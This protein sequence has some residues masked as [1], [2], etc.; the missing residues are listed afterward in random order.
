MVP[1]LLNACTDAEHLA[2]KVDFC[3]SLHM[4]C[5]ADFNNQFGVAAPG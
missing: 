2:G 1:S 5:L 3:I 4:A